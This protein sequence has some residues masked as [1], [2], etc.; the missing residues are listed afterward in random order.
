MIINNQKQICIEKTCHCWVD[1]TDVVSA[2]LWWTDKPD[3]EEE[4]KNET[5]VP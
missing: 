2:I 4:D 3:E 5:M 1:R